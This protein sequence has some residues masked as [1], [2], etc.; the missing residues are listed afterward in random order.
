MIRE[1]RELLAELA[2]LNGDMP[3]LGLR[4]MDGSA[5]AAEQ[6]HYAQRLIA[7]GKWLRQRA[8][9]RVGVVIEGEVDIQEP[10]A[11]PAH[12]VE[13]AQLDWRP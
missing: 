2:R 3:T 4:M 13:P 1:E 5:S 10:L 9:G 8:E 11:L 7:V 12:A 6:E